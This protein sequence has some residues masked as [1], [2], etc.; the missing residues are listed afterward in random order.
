MQRH[1]KPRRPPKAPASLDLTPEQE[2]QARQAAIKR[3]LDEYPVRDWF[4]LSQ[5][6]AVERPRRQGRKPKWVGIDGLY[7]VLD[8]EDRLQALGATRG[9][10]K[11]LE[12]VLTALRKDAPERYGS[13]SVGALRKGFYE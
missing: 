3:V 7:L 11:R 1:V 8:V 5:R 13:H 6:L 12:R 2:R 10:P 4:D 9:E